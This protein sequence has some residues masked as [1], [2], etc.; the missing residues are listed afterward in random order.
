MA[1]ISDSFDAGSA[2][3]RASRHAEQSPVIHYNE[4]RIKPPPLLAVGPL[5]WIRKNLFASWADTILTFVSI[6]VIIAAVGSFLSWSIGAANWFAV[7][8]NLRL[9]MLGRYDPSAEWRVQLLVLITAATVG[10]A[11]AAWSRLSRSWLIAL[12]VLIASLFIVPPII[13]AVIPMPETYLAAGNVD[14][15]SAATTEVPQPQLGFIAR[16]GETITIELADQYSTDERALVGLHGFA[17]NATNLLLGIANTHLANTQRVA[18][19]EA[20]L[21]GDLLTANQRQVLQ[22]ELERLVIPPPPTQTF[23]VDTQTVSVRLLRGSTLEPILEGTLTANSAPLSVTLEEDGWYVLQKTI[24]EGEGVA[25]LEVS[26]IYP[27]L[28][29]EF[30]GGTSGRITQYVRMTDLFLTQE[31][32]PA[33]D[34]QNVPMAIIIDNKYRG[35]KPLDEYLR[36]FLGPF[37]AQLSVPFLLIG[38]AFGAGYVIAK[39]VDRTFSPPEMPRK[40][41]RRFATWLLIALPVLMFVLVYGAG[42]PLPF[43][44]TR[45]WGGLL[46]TIMLTVVGIIASFPIGV[47]LA[48]GRRSHLPVISTACTLYIE[49]VRG[50]PLITV[51]FMAQLLVPLLN[52]QLAEVDNVFRAMVAIVL[53]SAAYLAENVRGGLQAIPHGQEE[54]A[55]AVGLN[56][57]QITMFITLPQALRIVLPALVGQFISLFKD[58]S[59][60]AIV[61]LLDLTNM[62]DNIVGQ[63]EFIGLRRETL[64]FITIIYFIF[65]YAIAAVSRR[66]EAS[67]SGSARRV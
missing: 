43:T 67:G 35:V 3:E 42:G 21:A 32:R 39:A 56:G 30:L 55:K 20:L 65:S 58:T 23:A 14:I 25:L 31:A 11:L 2:A 50:V 9:L 40:Y 49:F 7:T 15:T 6:A 60:V 12:V 16:A 51:L 4:P 46:L 64:I 63:T 38:L 57:Y 5:A 10:V 28:V 54:A 41:A 34:G 62:A 52:P 27:M 59:L 45:N 8:F 29:R 1:S 24:A 44:D 26:G 33:P 47:L 19:I 13:A 48:L 37:M 61:G 66:I 18:E 17:D 53:F 22:A 36:L